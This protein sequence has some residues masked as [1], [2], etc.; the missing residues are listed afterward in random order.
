MKQT[1][2]ATEPDLSD[3]ELIA[4]LVAD[5]SEQDLTALLHEFPRES[6]VVLAIY[7]QFLARGRD[8]PGALKGQL[9]NALARCRLHDE[10]EVVRDG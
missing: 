1:A 5:A 10:A 8:W 4:S 3:E 9:A 2:P 6:D 7:E